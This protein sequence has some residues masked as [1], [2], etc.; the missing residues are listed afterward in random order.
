MANLVSIVCRFI[1]Q[2]IEEMAYNLFT[3]LKHEN[4]GSTKSES[5]EDPLE[6]LAKISQFMSLIG[7]AG[8]IGGVFLA[9]PFLTIVYTE[10]WATDSA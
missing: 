5:K 6:I 2:P 4:E 8:M 10:K 9:K 7:F 3:K 1:F